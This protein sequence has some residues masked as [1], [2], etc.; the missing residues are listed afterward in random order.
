[1]KDLKKILIKENIFDNS[2]EWGIAALRIIPSF[3]LFYYH[4]LRKIM[5][6]TRT[7][8]WLGEAAMPLLGIDFGYT[9]FGFLAALSE[10][11]LTWL[12]IFGLWTRASSIFI[13][14][15]MFLAGLY[16]LVDGE[17][18]EMAF[19]YFTVYLAILILGPGKYSLDHKLY[20]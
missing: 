10:G 7:W 17:S 13:I 16:H 19:I 1:M 12:V 4:G 20:S 15:T 8:N 18:A 6:G 9:F 3:Y 5:N 14:I 11:V 2:R